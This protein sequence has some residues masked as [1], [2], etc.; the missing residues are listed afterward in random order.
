MTKPSIKVDSSWY[1]AALTEADA[2]RVGIEPATREFD[3]TRA[4]V[5]INTMLQGWNMNLHFKKIEDLQL[6]LVKLTGLHA[7]WMERLE[8]EPPA[9]IDSRL[10]NQAN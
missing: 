3:Q 8:K 9:S 4:T 10:G 6:L 2:L 7:E 1:T 5:S